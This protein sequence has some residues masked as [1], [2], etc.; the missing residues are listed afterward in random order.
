MYGFS[1]HLFD[2]AARRNGWLTA[3]AGLKFFNVYGPN[4]YHKGEMMNVARKAFVQARD[5]GA[6]RLF[7]S[8]SENVPDGGQLRDFVYV[9]D[10]A[11]VVAWLLEHPGACGLFNVGTGRARSFNDLARAVFAALERPERIE[12]FDMPGVLRGALPGLHRGPHGPPADRR[13]RQGVHQ[14]GGTE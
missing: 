13:V 7:R 10:C 4:E 11:E 6:V 3:M 14:P 9:K 8:D 1:K 2:L 5:Q 12:Y